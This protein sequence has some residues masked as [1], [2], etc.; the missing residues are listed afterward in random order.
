[1]FER[2]ICNELSITFHCSTQL[3]FSHALRKMQNFLLDTIVLVFWLIL[4][5]SKVSFPQ[6]QRQESIR[7]QWRGCKP[8]DNL[9]SLQESDRWEYW[10]DQTREVNFRINEWD[11]FSKY[12]W[13]N[14][15]QLQ[16]RYWE[17]LWNPQEICL[18]YKNWYCKGSL[19]K[20]R[21]WKSRVSRAHWKVKVGLYS[22]WVIC[23]D[24]KFNLPWGIHEEGGACNSF[25]KVLKDRKDSGLLL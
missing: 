2:T 12:A 4:W 25:M 23:Q 17:R 19:S 16:L 9:W 8:L 1:M 10:P 14:M 20:W 7:N 11:L 18:E 15:L 5:S 22:P 24:E 6:A 3:Y 13:K 21:P